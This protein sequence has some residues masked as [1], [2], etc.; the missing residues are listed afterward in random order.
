[1]GLSGFAFIAPLL[2]VATVKK[3]ELKSD[4]NKII[5]HIPKI[6]VRRL[7]KCASSRPGFLFPP[8]LDCIP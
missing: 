7:G 2:D 5:F 1:M 6:F 4:R 3:E 8:R